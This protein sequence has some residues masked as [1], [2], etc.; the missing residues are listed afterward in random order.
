[1]DLSSATPDGQRRL[2][3]VVD[4]GEWDLPNVRW[5]IQEKL[6]AYAS[7]ALD[8]QMFRVDPGSVGKPVTI[9]IRPVDPIPPDIAGFIDQIAAVLAQEGLAVTVEPLLAQQRRKPCSPAP[10]HARARRAHGRAA[11]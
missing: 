1:M 8:G 2:I 7:Y 3:I 10:V 4:K 9:V 6:N 11:R 5:L